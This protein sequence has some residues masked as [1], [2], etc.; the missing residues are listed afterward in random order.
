MLPP[1]TPAPPRRLA[2]AARFLRRGQRLRHADAFAALRA[3]CAMPLILAAAMPCHDAA[4]VAML[5]ILPCHDMPIFC[6]LF[7][8]AA[9]RRY[10]AYAIYCR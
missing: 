2:A 5:I 8:Y 9:L 10:F 1:F 7:D 6:L 3:Y 4:D